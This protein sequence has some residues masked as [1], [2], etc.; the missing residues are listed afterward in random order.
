MIVVEKIKKQIN[1][2]NDIE[3]FRVSFDVENNELTLNWE[4]SIL[5]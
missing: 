3:P 2:R 4:M 1:E 5:K